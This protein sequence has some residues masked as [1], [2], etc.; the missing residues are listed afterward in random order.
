MA[1]LEI[2]PGQITVH[3]HAFGDDGTVFSAVAASTFVAGP[4]GWGRAATPSP[5]A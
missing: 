1:G 3:R 5:E 2:A 4:A